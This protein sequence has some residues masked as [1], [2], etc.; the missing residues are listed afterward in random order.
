M[1]D[2]TLRRWLIG[3]Q[4]SPAA[5]LRAYLGQLPAHVK[6][7]FVNEPERAAMVAGFIPDL[8]AK[9]ILKLRD[10]VE[11]ALS[12]VRGRYPEMSFSV[13]GLSVLS[14]ARSVDVIGQL[15]RSLFSAVIVV[16]VLIGITFRS[17]QVALFSVLPT[18]FA[19]VATGAL[20][21]TLGWGL[22]YASIMALT[23]AYGLAVD[24]TIHFL[25]RFEYERGQ[26]PTAAEAAYRTI[27]RIGPIVVMSTLVLMI[28]MAVTTFSGVPPTRTFGQLT[29]AT[30][31]FALIGI[32]IILP[33]TIVTASRWAWFR[34][35]AD[36]VSKLVA[37]S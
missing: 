16:I 11:A 8:E 17:L 35:D 19:L 5:D 25:S 28:G 10:D 2:R 33:A 18:Q 12:S 13:T 29:I 23:I 31:F 22:E 20:L 7:R 9:T 26:R 27:A 1:V 32:M 30:L 34:P 21:H 3:D 37:R 4:R 36:K 6:A 24:D 14:S 15:N